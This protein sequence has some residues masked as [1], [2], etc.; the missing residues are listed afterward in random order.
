MNTKKKNVVIM[1]FLIMSVLASGC[2]GANSQPKISAV[3]KGADGK[4]KDLT[5]R[6]GVQ[7]SGGLFGKAREEKWFEEEFGKLGVKVEW[8][9]FQ[10]GPPMTEAMA[11]N[12]LDFAGL[13]NMPII[14]AQAADIQFKVIS[15]SLHGQKNV[16]II[17][18][19]GSTAQTL[20]D[21]K[22]KKIAVTKGSN[23]FNFLYRGLADQGIKVSDIEIIQLQPDEAQ[24]AFESGGVDAWATW[25][26]YITLNTLTGKGKVLADGEQ[27]GVLSPSFN[28]VRKDF[29][30]QY[31]DLV[32]LYLTVL[33]KTLAWE[34][35]NEAEALKRYAD[36]RGIPQEVIQGTFDRSRSIN[37]P[38]TDAIIAE[39]Q[40][41][42][43]F[44]FEQKTIRKK[45]QV[46]DV[47][48]NQYIEAASK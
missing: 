10:S 17:V 8:S 16:A 1:L 30:D 12:R 4:Y 7:G 11:S 29:A 9:E 24:P 15:Q 23:A 28:I 14:A 37:I 22:G 34:K 19:P 2:A 27:L 3:E 38:V 33:N 42:A 20:S 43:D 31:P 21:L 39:Q 6:L 40:K 46:K 41:T 45:I 36:E 35:E 48:D 18:P 13:G 5:V 47:F 26:P 32:T 25:D 44:Q